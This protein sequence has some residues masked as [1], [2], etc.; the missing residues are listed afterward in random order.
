M[1]IDNFDSSVNVDLESNP[2]NSTQDNEIVVHAQELGFCDTQFHEQKN[3]DCNSTLILSNDP[4]TL[5]IEDTVEEEFKIL[6]TTIECDNDNS[7]IDVTLSSSHDHSGLLI[8]NS[9]LNQIFTHYVSLETINQSYFINIES[10]NFLHSE[11]Y[12]SL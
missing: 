9:L 7:I 2:V 10:F 11:T 5:V 1:H 4:E 12:F 8:Q 6:D 3:K